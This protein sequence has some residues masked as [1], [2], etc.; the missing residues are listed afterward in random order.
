MTRPRVL[1][2]DNQDSFTYNLAQAL[3]A[4]GASVLVRRSDRGSLAQLAQLP[5]SH[6]VLSP[7]PG[8]PR[9]A[10]LSLAAVRRWA[11]RRPLLGVCLG[12]QALAHA[13]G[14]R[15]GRAAHPLHGR[16]SAVRHDGQG[17]FRGLPQAFPAGRYHSLAVDPGSLPADLRVT[18]VSDDGTVMGLRHQGG[19]EGIQF[20]PESI[21]T[22]CGK[23]LLANFLSPC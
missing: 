9:Q 15:V 3:E 23:R 22:P 10:R 12:H 18:A 17:L 5:A 11:L 21:L 16:A 1:L 13:F 6:V 7:G 2:L 8:H 14:A 4:L 19:A 20:H